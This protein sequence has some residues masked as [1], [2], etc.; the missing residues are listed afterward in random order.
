MS[1]KEEFDECPSFH[2]TPK[3][4][5]E[6]L[7]EDIEFKAYDETL[8]PCIGRDRNFYD[9]IP[10]QKDWGEIEQGRDIFE[11]DYGRKF[12]KVIVNPPYKTNHKEPK[13]RKNIAMKFIFRCLELCMDE[14]WCLLNLQMFN[15]LTPNRL[16]D[17]TEMG[18]GVVSIKV[19]NI[20]KWYGRYFWVCF[21]KLDESGGK[22]IL[23]Y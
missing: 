17:M 16:K 19:V 7:L 22:N 2:Y 18:F 8:E 12:A 21:K 4:I 11:Y 9:K 14:C 23:Q 15:S 6:K 1:E 5:C 10:Y 13:D 20:S 3:D